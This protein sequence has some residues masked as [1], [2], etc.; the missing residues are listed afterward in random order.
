FV[1]LTMVFGRIAESLRKNL[2]LGFS[3]PQKSAFAGLQEAI[4]SRGEIAVLC[5]R[6]DGLS[7]LM[8]G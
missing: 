5:L 2:D 8:S 6:S 3:S 1:P 4:L 7:R